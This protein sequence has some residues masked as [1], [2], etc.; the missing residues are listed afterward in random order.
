MKTLIAALIGAGVLTSVATPASTQTAA[1][2]TVC[3]KRSELVS[4]LGNRFKEA[5]S[6]LG[7][8][9][10]G[11][12]VEI[13]TSTN[14]SWSILMTTP[15]GMSCLIAAGEFWQKLPS[16]VAGVKM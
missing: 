12:V 3:D 11:S 1:R 2:G 7:L 16:P 13:L 6:A 10:N 8:A 4:A 9:A 14:G 5:P 15:K